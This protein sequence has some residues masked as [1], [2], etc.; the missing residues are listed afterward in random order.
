MYTVEFTNQGWVVFHNIRHYMFPVSKAMPGDFG[1]ASAS[2]LAY[3]L[4]QKANA[5]E[6]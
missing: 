1:K 2:E 6:E 3:A 5:A 4:N